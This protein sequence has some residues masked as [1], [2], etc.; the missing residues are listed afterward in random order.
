M[1]FKLRV[2]RFIQRQLF[3]RA[4]FRSLDQVL[5]VC[6]NLLFGLRA[7]ADFNWSIRFFLCISIAIRCC[8]RRV[9]IVAGAAASA[10]TVKLTLN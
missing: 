9:V 5:R 6:G 7:G 3:L 4:G 1:A 8:R 2:D 10:E